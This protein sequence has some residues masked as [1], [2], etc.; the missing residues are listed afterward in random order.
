MK[1]IS[2]ATLAE[3]SKKRKTKH[4]RFLDEMDQ[5]VPWARLMEL[6]EPHYPKAGK[7][8]RP[9]GLETMQTSRIAAANSL[10]SSMVSGGK[11]SGVFGVVH[12]ATIPA[13][14]RS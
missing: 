10:L 11:L 13:M 8:R 4:Q 12:A 5:V 3:T 6:I 9:R 1:Q 2:F 14:P 7:G